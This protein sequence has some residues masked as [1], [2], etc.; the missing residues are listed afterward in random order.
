MF[1]EKMRKEL[2]VLPHIKGKVVEDKK[3]VKIFLDERANDK[4]GSRR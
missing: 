3:K 1:F 4:K 2:F